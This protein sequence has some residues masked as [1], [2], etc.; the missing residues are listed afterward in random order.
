VSRRKYEI[1]K[2]E[3]KGKKRR[4]KRK[5]RTHRAPK[6]NN[7]NSN[8]TLALSRPKSHQTPHNRPLPK[9]KEF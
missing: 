7:N 4:K 8:N 9:R 5:G 6:E 3:R 1:I 2:D